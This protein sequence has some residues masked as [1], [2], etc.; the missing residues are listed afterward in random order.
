[1]S[2]TKFQSYRTHNE[3]LLLNLNAHPLLNPLNYEEIA[4]DPFHHHRCGDRSDDC[5]PLSF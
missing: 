1:M 3:P 2:Q 4:E 5:N